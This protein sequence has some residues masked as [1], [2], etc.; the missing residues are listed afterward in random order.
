VPLNSLMCQKIKF[1]C[2]LKRAQKW[3]RI[4]LLEFLVKNHSIPKGIYKRAAYFC[5]A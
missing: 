3:I 4:A 1:F 5:F 2:T